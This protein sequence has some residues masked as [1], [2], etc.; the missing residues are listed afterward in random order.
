MNCV[1]PTVVMTEMGRIAWSDPEKANPM[2]SR[3]PLKRFAGNE[4]FVFLRS[5]LKNL[6]L[7]E[8]DEVVDAVVFLLSDR[9]SMINAA[10]L[11]VDGGFL[12]C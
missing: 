12:G 2:L 7:L 9:S 5:S 1:N 11:P 3:I 4:E 8:I 6:I 10:T